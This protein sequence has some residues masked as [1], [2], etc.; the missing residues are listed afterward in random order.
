MEVWPA[1][2]ILLVIETITTVAVISTSQT[3]GANELRSESV[4]P[5][6]RCGTGAGLSYPVAAVTVRLNEGLWG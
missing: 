6:L 1:S 4:L 3:K 2:A 5:G